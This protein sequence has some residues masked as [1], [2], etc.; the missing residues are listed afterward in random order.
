MKRIITLWKVGMLIGLMALGGCNGSG[1]EPLPPAATNDWSVSLSRSTTNGEHVTVALR[2]GDTSSYG[3]LVP[4]AEGEKATW[5]NDLKPEWPTDNT[6]AVEA[7]AF[8]PAVT[9]LP[10]TVSAF[11]SIAYRMD[12]IPCTSETKPSQ[13]TLTHLMAQL[14]VHIQLHDDEAHHY[15]PTDAVINLFTKAQ[16]DY[17]HKQLTDSTARMEWQLGT[18]DRENESFGSDENWVNTP[19]VVVPQTFPAGEPCLS[20][21]AGEITYTFVPENSITL[22]AGKRT[23][24]Y[25][26][27]AY[28]NAHAIQAGFSITDWAEG[29]TIS[30]NIFNSDNN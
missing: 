7:I 24:I 1:E 14:V 3:T 25:L 18:F 8:C 19:Q 27:V 11:D 9:A 21:R 5:L 30:D 28:E 16:V 15:R 2:Y 4:A 26:G 29:E 23:N 20:F 17:T 12:Y 10:Q 22:T 13:F 6:T